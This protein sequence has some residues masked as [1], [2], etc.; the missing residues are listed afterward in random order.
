[1]TRM[2][3]RKS[4]RSG[5]GSNCVEVALSQAAAVRDS[6]NTSGPVLTFPATAWSAFVS[7]LG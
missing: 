2:E 7:V 1:M 5:S 6:K 3:W 4:S